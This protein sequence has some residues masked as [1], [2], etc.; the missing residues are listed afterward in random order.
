MKNK[1]NKKILAIL[2]ST[3]GMISEVE[4]ECFVDARTIV[5]GCVELLHLDTENVLLLNE[6]GIA[7]ELPVNPYFIDNGC[8][9]GNV[10]LAKTHDLESI[11]YDLKEC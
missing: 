1:Q 2:F 7:L 4:I 5:G 11:P 9:L 6:D 8:I 3:E 10:L